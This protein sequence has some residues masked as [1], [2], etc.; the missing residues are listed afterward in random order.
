MNENELKLLWQISNERLANCLTTNKQTA[1]DL[2]RLK[3]GNLLS[4][5]KPVKVFTLMVGIV[6]VI[7]LGSFLVHLLVNHITEIS[8]FF[9]CSA[10]AQVLLTAVA[11]GVYLYQFDLIN[12]IDFSAPV[13]EIQ[14]KLS[15]LKISTLNV[16]RLLFLQLPLWTTFYWNEEMF[17]VENWWLWI[18]QVF[19][20]VSLTFLSVWLFLNIKY[21]NRNAK[22][23]Q[24]IFNGREWQPLLRAMELLDQIERY[25]EQEEEAPVG[26]S[27]FA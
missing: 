12:N 24:W 16:T 11:I 23:F 20:T 4:S 17:V 3:A 18:F 19:V 10:I 7:A 26:D 27:G 14:E 22:W 6:W 13:L 25:Q 5:M 21:E 9:L 15:K 8:L 1:E 2:N